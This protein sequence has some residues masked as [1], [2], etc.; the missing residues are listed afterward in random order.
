MTWGLFIMTLFG[1]LPGHLGTIY[2]YGN[3][4]HLRTDPTRQDM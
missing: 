4:G 3:V 2:D 1:A